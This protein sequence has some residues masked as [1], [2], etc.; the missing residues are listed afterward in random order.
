[1]RW[2]NCNEEC[3]V[4]ASNTGK[5]ECDM[6]PMHL[7]TAPKVRHQTFKLDLTIRRRHRGERSDCKFGHIGADLVGSLE[8]GFV[9][10]A[11]GQIEH[12]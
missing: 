1:M 2:M 3:H 10:R 8:V 6:V 9:C 5:Q 4:N 12:D 11:K 7:E